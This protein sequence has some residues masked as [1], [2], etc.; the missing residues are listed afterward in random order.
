MLQGQSL[1]D[2]ETRED[3]LILFVP[4]FGTG[5]GVLGHSGRP[6]VHILFPDKL[7]FSKPS[8]LDWADF[9]VASSH[10]PH[11]GVPGPDPFGRFC[12]RRSGHN[13][14]PTPPPAL[15]LQVPC[16]QRLPRHLPHLPAD[17]RQDPLQG[18][19]VRKDLSK[20][21]KSLET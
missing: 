5:T 14:L 21:G 20:Q 4:P 3:I 1:F 10:E 16:H 2:I 7:W 18:T 15:L 6:K 11:S 19:P 17:V 13:R 9:V 8:I 12:S